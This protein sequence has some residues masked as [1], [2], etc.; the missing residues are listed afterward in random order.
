MD[1]YKN[2]TDS[3]STNYISNAYNRQTSYIK[4]DSSNSDTDS[5]SSDEETPFVIASDTSLGKMIPHP[6][7]TISAILNDTQT[8][9]MFIDSGDR[10]I[11]NEHLFKFNIKCSPPDKNITS[12]NTSCEIIKRF[13]DVLSVTCKKL[14]MPDYLYLKKTI[15]PNGKII[16]NQ[17]SSEIY[18]SLNPVPSNLEGTNIISRNCNFIVVPSFKHNDI[19]TYISTNVSDEYNTP[20]NYLNFL[21]LKINT[22]S[23]HTFNSQLNAFSDNYHKS[24]DFHIISKIE[25]DILNSLIWFTL[26]EPCIQFLAELG[27]VIKVFFDR[28]IIEQSLLSINICNFILNIFL[29]KSYVIID[30]NIELD[31]ISGLPAVTKVAIILNRKNILPFLTSNSITINNLLEIIN[32]NFVN[33]FKSYILNMSMQYKIVID[34]KY[35]IRRLKQHIHSNS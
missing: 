34:I 7:N 5:T 21:E 28:N 25:F 10:D 23:T 1:K 27:T 29:N 6:Q 32:T 14:I 17:L 19:V 22:P 2:E 18:I 33:N 16:D 3:V 11:I 30:R 12:L 9:T 26:K 13:S 4:K 31:P 35:K 24:P 15:L 20:I 8:V